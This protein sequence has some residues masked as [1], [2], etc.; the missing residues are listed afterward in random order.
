MSELIDWLDQTWLAGLVIDNTWG[1]PIAESLHFCGLVMIFGTVSLVDLRVIGYVRWVSFESVHRLII[2][3]ITGIVIS[4]ITGAMFISAAAD[5]YFYNSAFHWKLVFFTILIINLI[6]FYSRQYPAVRRLAPG[7]PAP[8]A[9]RVSAGISLIA[10]IG[11]MS[12]GRLLTF[13]RPAFYG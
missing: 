7:D 5:Q 12:A 10:M 2:I 13:Y 9:A 4:A 11:V 6:Y 1:W 3:A 8:M